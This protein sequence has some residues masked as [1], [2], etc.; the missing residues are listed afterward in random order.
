M[1]IS[2]EFPDDVDA[3]GPGTTLVLLLEQTDGRQGKGGRLIS[4]T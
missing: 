4:L 3:S 2:N 1:Y